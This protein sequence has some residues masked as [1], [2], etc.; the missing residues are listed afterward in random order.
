M[1]KIA[2]ALVIVACLLTGALLPALAET[3]LSR[4]AAA[5]EPRMEEKTPGETE[6]PA[7]EETPKA[8]D[9]REDPA[10][11][12]T[13]PAAPRATLAPKATDGREDR[14]ASETEPEAPKATRAPKATD[15]RED[16]AAT[17]TEPAAP[18][19]TRAPKATDG[20]E[21]PATPEEK[22]DAFEAPEPSQR[23]GHHGAAHPHGKRH[24]GGE[25]V[26]PGPGQTC[27]AV[28]E[29]TSGHGRR[30]RIAAGGAGRSGAGPIAPAVRLAANVPAGKTTSPPKRCRPRFPS[31][32]P[33]RQ[34]NPQR[35]RRFGWD[36][37]WPSESQSGG[38]NA[39]PFF[40]PC[41]R[42]VNLL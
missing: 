16:P 2:I 32:N 12:E 24:H 8:T 30:P 6:L 37:E 34:R 20:R 39:P 5:E 38:K 7:R 26:R 22:P 23:H 29:Q 11:S 41:Y 31:R 33:A 14:A 42:I 3:D 18:K 1:K 15:G 17:E 36:P 35:R 28:P 19:A 27:R 40:C 25:G 10:A 21:D 13:E 9:G 4:P